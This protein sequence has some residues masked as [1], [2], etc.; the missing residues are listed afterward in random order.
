VNA[1]QAVQASRQA[2]TWTLPFTPTWTPEAKL[3]VGLSVAFAQTMYCLVHHCASAMTTALSL[4]VLVL[5]LHSDRSVGSALLR[6]VQ[7]LI[8]SCSSEACQLCRLS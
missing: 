1:E 8:L 7:A 5:L 2:P 6:L 3:K 4:I